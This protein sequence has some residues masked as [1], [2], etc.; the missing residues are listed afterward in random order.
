ML[1]GM[2]MMLGCTQKIRRYGSVIG[3]KEQALA[4]YKELHANPW[5]EVNAKLKEANMQNYSIYL[6]QFPDVKYYL[7]SYFEYVGNDYEADIA[8]MTAVPTTQK[9][10]EECMPCQEPLPDRAEGEWWAEMEEVFH[11]D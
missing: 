9:W 4:K 7:F 1:F 2:I 3:V 10:W 6:T 5:P 8:K 11:L